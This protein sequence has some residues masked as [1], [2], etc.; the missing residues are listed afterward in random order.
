MKKLFK[1]N[2]ISYTPT[3]FFQGKQINDNYEIEDIEK[4]LK[5]YK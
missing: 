5:H 2:R 1:E 3:F 4:I